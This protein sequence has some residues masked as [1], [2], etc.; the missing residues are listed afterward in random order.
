MRMNV[1]YEQKSIP[2]NISAVCGIQFSLFERMCKKEHIPKMKKKEREKKK[3]KKK[4]SKIP[5]T[6]IL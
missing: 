2:L 4:S 1:R 5:I 6:A 3:P